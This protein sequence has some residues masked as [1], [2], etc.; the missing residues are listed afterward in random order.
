VLLNLRLLQQGS[1]PSFLDRLIKVFLN[2]VPLRLATLREDIAQEEAQA[3]EQQAHALLGSCAS[4]GAHH[5]ASVCA[6]LETIARS[7][8][9]RH[10]QDLLPRLEDEFDRTRK[11]LTEELAS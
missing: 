4:L 9:L 3:I 1:K 6:E 10:T 7:G 2:D 8:D 5:M 11:A